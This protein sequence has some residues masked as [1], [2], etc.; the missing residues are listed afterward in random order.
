MCVLEM[1]KSGKIAG[2]AKM[3]GK[4]PAYN[5]Q[6]SVQANDNIFLLQG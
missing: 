3:V 1:D 4:R 2:H 6:R 5:I